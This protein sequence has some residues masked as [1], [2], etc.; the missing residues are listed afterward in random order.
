MPWQR[1]TKHRHD[2]KRILNLELLKQFG[3]EPTEI[4]NIINAIIVKHYGLCEQTERLN[5]D[6]SELFMRSHFVSDARV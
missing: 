4:I 5:V 3:P 2:R 6:G 1:R